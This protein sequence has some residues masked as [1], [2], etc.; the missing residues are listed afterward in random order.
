MK[1]ERWEKDL[2]A[3]QRWRGKNDRWRRINPLSVAIMAVVS[4]SPAGT[5]SL[6]IVASVMTAVSLLVTVFSM[7]FHSPVVIVSAGQCL[8]GAADHSG[9]N[10]PHHKLD[11]YG[12]EI[13]SACYFHKIT[14][15]PDRFHSPV[16]RL[17]LEACLMPII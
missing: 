10:K 9:E 14:P 16:R 17:S 2:Y 7:F 4:I 15:F 13:P 3:R 12:S 5:P 8:T 6:L 11:R 1:N